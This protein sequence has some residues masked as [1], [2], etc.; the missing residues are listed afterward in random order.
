[1]IVN[2]VSLNEITEDLELLSDNI[3]T[4]VLSILLVKP[5]T[6]KIYNISIIKIFTFSANLISS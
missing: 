3:S 2:Y 1:M 6:Y 4:N 5:N